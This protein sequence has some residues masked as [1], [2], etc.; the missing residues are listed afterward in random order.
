MQAHSFFFSVYEKCDMCNSQLS[1][2]PESHTFDNLK[3]EKQMKWPI[4]TKDL[5]TF[6]KSKNL[7]NQ[8]PVKSHIFGSKPE[9]K[10]I[11]I[12]FYF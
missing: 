8:I 5:I 1:D 10:V 6:K 4:M 2:R 11:F 12:L 9:I 3:C 7:E